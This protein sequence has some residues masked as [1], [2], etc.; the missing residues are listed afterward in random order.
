MQGRSKVTANEGKL[1]RDLE[2]EASD[3]TA[4]MYELNCAR[5]QSGENLWSAKKWSLELTVKNMAT[6]GIFCTS[7]KTE[8]L[9][10]E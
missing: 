6:P 4:Y 9:P 7:C 3:F 5:E 2:N 8:T 1:D 10:L